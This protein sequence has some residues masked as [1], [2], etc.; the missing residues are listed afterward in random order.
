LCLPS[1]LEALSS[2]SRT[3]KKQAN[4]TKQKSVIPAMPD[5]EIGGSQSSHKGE[6]LFEKYLKQKGLGAWP[7]Q[8]KTCLASLRS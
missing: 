8:L 7:E 5:A 6:A 4:K 1:R 2:N 3:A